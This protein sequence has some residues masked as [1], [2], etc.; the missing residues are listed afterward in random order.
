MDLQRPFQ[1][2]TPTVDGD[3]LFV[4]SAAASQFTPPEI[5]RLAGRHSVEGVRRALQRLESQGV[6]TRTKVGQAFAYQLNRS[7]LAASHIVGLAGLR[8]ELMRR[9]SELL[10]SWHQPCE[11]AALF[12]SVA[13]GSASVASDLDVF[14][15]R[16]DDRD[17]DEPAWR[18]Q[19]D[20][21]AQTC[22]AWTGND[23][24]LLEM[25]ASEV[26][27]GLQGSARRVLS[28]IGRQGQTLA[29]DDGYVRVKL[30]R[31]APGVDS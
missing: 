1:T 2:V 20:D 10:E 8:G 15:V 22:T 16:P 27:R 5:H 3:V 17:A 13:T 18:D 30:Q 24:R 9:M 23:T 12:G 28:D 25:S 19:C 26:S 31:R 7:H 14:I 6:V 4:L 11:Y 21:F 29:G